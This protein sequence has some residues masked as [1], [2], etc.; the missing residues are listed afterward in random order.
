MYYSARDSLERF[1]RV[2]KK[3]DGA[4]EVESSCPKKIIVYHD[5]RV[6]DFRSKVKLVEFINKLEAERVENESR[7]N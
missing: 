6:K 2:L 5:A 3:H 4:I 7:I 1:N